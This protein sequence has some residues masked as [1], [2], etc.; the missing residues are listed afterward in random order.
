MIAS[1]R[2]IDIVVD[3]NAGQLQITWQDGVT[4][5][6]PL[7]WL[8]AHCPCATC[9]EERR[10]AAANVNELR[11]HTGPLPSTEIA[12]AELV[13]NYAIRLDWSDGHSTGIYPFIELRSAAESAKESE[14][15]GLADLLSEPRS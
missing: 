9:M 11:L 5:S 1:M 3:R 2:P 6:Y 12:G 14:G 13:G 7:D 4:D 8:R 10:E 15:K